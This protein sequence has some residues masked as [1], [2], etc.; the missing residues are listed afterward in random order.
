MRR[1]TLGGAGGAAGYAS[2]D[3]VWL[4]DRRKSAARVAWKGGAIKARHELRHTQSARQGQQIRQH[5][6]QPWFARSSGSP[7]R[8]L[9]AF[10]QLVRCVFA[11]PSVSP[12]AHSRRP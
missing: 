1:W 5:I 4:L 6:S 12:Q 2:A 11:C 3:V 8:R 10:R 9:M 7:K